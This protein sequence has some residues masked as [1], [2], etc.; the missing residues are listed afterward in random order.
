MGFR[1]DRFATLYVAKP[2]H[3]LTSSRNLSVAVLMYHNVSDVLD[4]NEKGAHP[5][6]RTST[7]PQIFAA[8]MKSLHDNGYKT[9]T[10]SDIV[11]QFAHPPTAIQRRIVITFDDGYRDFYTNAFPILQRYGFTA[12]VYLPTVYIGDRN[13][14]FKGKECMSWA[15]VREL[16]RSGI[17]FGSHTMSHP[18]LWNLRFSEIDTE[19][20]VSKETI[21]DKLGYSVESFAYPYAF[22]Q[23]DIV[24]TSRMRDLLRSAGYQNGVS[25]MVGRAN[26]ASDPFFLERLP[27]NSCDD[28]S[29]FAAKLAGAYDWI[30]KLQYASKK[31]KSQ[32]GKFLGH[33]SA[34]FSTVSQDHRY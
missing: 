8:Q 17:S 20:R 11:R 30:G 10:C 31:A 5:Y 22:P 16:H 34:S 14:V 9:V 2:L 32:I 25:T 4:H 28:P 6:Y 12:A 13:K 7:S 1:V 3:R 21:E 15:E 29:L 19:L 23:A 26:A 18:Q 33:R 24:F 27:V